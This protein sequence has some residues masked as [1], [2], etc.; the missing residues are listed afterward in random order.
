M[1]ALEGDGEAESGAAKSEQP[2][3]TG[4]AA[5]NGMADSDGAPGTET[6]QERKRVLWPAAAGIIVFAGI[7]F[8]GVMVKKRKKED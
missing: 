6:G 3:E 4:G 5:G 8:A 1:I 7:V 2:E